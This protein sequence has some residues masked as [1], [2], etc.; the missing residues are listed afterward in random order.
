LTAARQL[1]RVRDVLQAI[2]DLE[3]LCESVSFPEFESDRVRRAAFERFVEILSEASRSVP[4]DLK[5]SN[6]HIP[7]KR[8]ANIG[9]HLRLAYHQT[10]PELLWNLIAHQHLADLKATCELF[11][12][13]S[14]NKFTN[15]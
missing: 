9:N 3:Q 8:I 10:D 5:L 4:D 13:I 12:E 1:Q 6:E 15:T 7:W 2:K 11:L 14:E